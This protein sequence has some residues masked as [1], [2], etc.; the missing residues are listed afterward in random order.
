MSFRYR[1]PSISNQWK[2]YAKA[3][4]IIGTDRSG[5]LF[6]ANHAFDCIGAKAYGM[7]AAFIDPTQAAVYAPR[8]GNDRLLLGLKGSLNE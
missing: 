1:R 6:A 4:E 3:E 2:T 5:I 8:R 7:R